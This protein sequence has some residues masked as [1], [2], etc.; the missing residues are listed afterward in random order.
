MARWHIPCERML[1]ALEEF[2]R[3]IELPIELVK[4][5]I[6]EMAPLMLQMEQIRYR[7]RKPKKR[8]R[9]GNVIPFKQKP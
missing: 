7:K 2:I 3:E 1:G 5:F 8:K 9:K 6:M 4:P